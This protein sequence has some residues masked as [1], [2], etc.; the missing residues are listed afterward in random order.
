MSAGFKGAKVI[1]ILAAPRL[2]CPPMRSGTGEGESAHTQTEVTTDL[3]TAR[4]RN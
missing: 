4:N 3:V 1:G 2:G